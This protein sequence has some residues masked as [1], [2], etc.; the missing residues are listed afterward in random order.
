[1]FS[2]LSYVHV[3]WTLFVE[4]HAVIYVNKVFTNYMLHAP[5]PRVTL[6]GH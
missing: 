6:G 3:T 5:L 4:L 2:N 1:M